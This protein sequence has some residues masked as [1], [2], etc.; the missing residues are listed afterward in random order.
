MDAEHPHRSTGEGE[1]DME[2]GEEKP[3]KGITFEI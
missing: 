3:R 1:R 2:F